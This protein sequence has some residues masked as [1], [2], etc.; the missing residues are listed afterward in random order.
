MTEKLKIF[1]P[2]A[3]QQAE[4][5]KLGVSG[6]GSCSGCQFSRIGGVAHVIDGLVVA[7]CG[8]GVNIRSRCLVV[9]Q[10]KK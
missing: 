7:Q 1:C 3:N 8:D 10:A 6:M 2:I 5:E 9:E 4:I